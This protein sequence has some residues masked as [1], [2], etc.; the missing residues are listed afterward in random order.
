MNSRFAVYYIPDAQ[1]SETKEFYELGS[2]FL[3]YDIRQQKSVALSSQLSQEIGGFELDWVGQAWF[4]GFHLTIG[5][6]I[7]CSASTLPKVAEEL[8][9]LLGCFDASNGFKL[10]QASEF[11]CRR[12]DGEIFLLHFEAN[13]S[14]KMFHAAVVT[15]LHPMGVGSLYTERLKKNSNLYSNSP[16]RLEKVKKFFSPTALDD[17]FPH[18]TL[19]NPYRG[20]S[21]D[22]VEKSFQKIFSKFK[23]LTVNRVVLLF[24]EEPGKAFRIYREFYFA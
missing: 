2:Q 15:L 14:L 17:F 22:R 24:Q 5:D 12:G 13:D 4:Y 16:S 21:P 23:S 10:S 18:F 1:A 3:G 20:Q 11:V 6:A 7:L 19:L 9:S 8:E